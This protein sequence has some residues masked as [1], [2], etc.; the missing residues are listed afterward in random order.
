MNGKVKEIS[1]KKIVLL[2]AL[3]V[4]AAS[5]IALVIFQWSNIRVLTYFLFYSEDRIADIKESNERAISEAID[6][7][8]PDV[9]IRDLTEDEREMLITG[10]LSQEEA[11]RLLVG[12]AVSTEVPPTAQGEGREV[13]PPPQLGESRVPLPPPQDSD[14]SVSQDRLAELLA[15]IY[16]LRAVFVSSLNNLEADA[17]AEYRALPSD[18]RTRAQ[19]LDIGMKYMGV[20]EN[21]EAECDAR[22]D[23]L[24]SKIEAEL[25]ASGGDLSLVSEIRSVYNNE[26]TLSKAEYL[27]LYTG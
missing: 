24:L 11:V 5:L 25:R 14:G 3:G 2:I 23:E 26:K 1:K 10:E 15:E 21:L 20:A 13:P 22:M 9:A 17:R 12:A 4:I 19:Q 18:R 8:I 7:M 27:S 16:V 6:R